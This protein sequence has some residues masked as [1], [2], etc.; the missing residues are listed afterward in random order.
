MSILKDIFGTNDYDKQKNIKNSTDD[1]ATL[2]LRKEE[3]IIDKNNI[4][5]GE[6]ELSKEI[7]EE[8][9]SMDV[10]VEREEVVI[11]RRILENQVSNSSI[12]NEESI[13]IPVSE[14]QVR[15]DKHTVIT[16]EVSA[17]KHVIEDTQHIEETLKREE[18]RINTTGDPNV[19]DNSLT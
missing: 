2:S 11:E 7:I 19:I 16:G 4:Q 12:T 9:R 6:V 18:A 17:H 10:P 15:V 5:T 13:R 3:L 1:S 8:Q 14:E